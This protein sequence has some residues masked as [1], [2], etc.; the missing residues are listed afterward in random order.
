MANLENFIKK[1]K[2]KGIQTRERLVS[3]PVAKIFMEEEILPDSEPKII[4]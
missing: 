1:T 2:Y 3:T 4:N